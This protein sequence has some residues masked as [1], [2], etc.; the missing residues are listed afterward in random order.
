MR[1]FFFVAGDQVAALEANAVPR[2]GEA[3]WIKTLDYEGSLI[4]ETIEHEFDRSRVENYTSHDVSLNC[5]K[6]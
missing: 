5:R 4:V 3:V 6:K 2:S 1:L